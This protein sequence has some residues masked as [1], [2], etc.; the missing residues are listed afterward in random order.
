MTQ[1]G[2]IDPATAQLIALETDIQAGRI[3]A[4]IAT[5]KAFNHAYPT[6]VRALLF[7][8][9]IAR[10]Q[11]KTAHELMALHRATMQAPKWPRAFLELAL[12]LSRENRH[13]EALTAAETAVALAPGERPPLETAIAVANGAGNAQAGLA[14]LKKAHALWPDDLVFDRQLGA[15]LTNLRRHDEA[16]RHWRELL[17]KHPG[18]S[19]AEVNYS[20]TLAALGRGDEAVALLERTHQREPDNAT[21][22]FYLASARGETPASQPPELVQGIFDGYADYF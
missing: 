10:A 21:V 16:D 4:A 17:T 6:D 7:D 13:V 12:T 20:M 22:A 14:F 3:D 8:A 19:T 18:D 5:L 15:M 9:L 11:I 1:P 2:P